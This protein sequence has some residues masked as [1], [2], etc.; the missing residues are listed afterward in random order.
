MSGQYSPGGAALRL[1]SRDMVDLDRPRDEAIS[2]TDAFDCLISAI[3]TLSSLVN[4]VYLLI[5]NSVLCVCFHKTLYGV[6]LHFRTGLLLV[7]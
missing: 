5:C 6:A 4:C 7:L 1:I 2:V 3:F